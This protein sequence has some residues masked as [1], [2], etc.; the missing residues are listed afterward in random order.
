MEREQIQPVNKLR[1]KVSSELAIV[2]QRMTSHQ[3][4]RELLKSSCVLIE[5]EIFAQNF[6][7][8]ANSSP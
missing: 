7:R 1:D 3:Y 5:R 8:I 6:A 4:Q 2:A